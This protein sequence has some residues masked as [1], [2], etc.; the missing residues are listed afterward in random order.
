MFR[1]AFLTLQTWRATVQVLQGPEL[2][3]SDLPQI[4]SKNNIFLVI[5]FG[6]LFE[7]LQLLSQLKLWEISAGSFR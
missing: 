5:V 4:S 1:Y 2:P 6:E 3:V 7:N